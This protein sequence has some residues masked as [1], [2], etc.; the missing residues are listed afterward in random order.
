[1]DEI[2]EARKFKSD[3]ALKGYKKQTL[4][5]VNSY[6]QLTTGKKF[7]TAEPNS[8]QRRA[9]DKAALRSAIQSARAMGLNKKKPAP[10]PAPPAKGFRDRLVR[11]ASQHKPVKAQSTTGG[12]SVASNHQ[13]VKE[14]PKPQT[15]FDASKVKIKQ[16]MSPDAK[17]VE[18]VRRQIMNPM[19]P[20]P[21]PEGMEN[22]VHVDEYL[23]HAVFNA[24][25]ENW[26][27]LHNALPMIKAQHMKDVAMG[28][29][30]NR[31]TKRKITREANRAYKY[32][33]GHA[34]NIEASHN[35]EH[36]RPG[37]LGRLKRAILGEDRVEIVRTIISEASER[38]RKKGNGR[39]SGR[40]RGEALKAAKHRTPG[41]LINRTRAQVEKGLEKTNTSK[42]ETAR[43]N[44]TRA[45]RMQ[46]EREAREKNK[47]YQVT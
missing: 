25:K 26:I 44:E 8:R 31:R 7:K 20:K 23:D 24:G 10:K 46:D 32:R 40:G 34:H 1:M 14:P 19:N 47:Q 6:R 37:I 11:H 27:G 17:R 43:A 41:A 35:P 13:T 22:H 38:M 3:K 16:E 15:G 21:R 42:R 5:L 12:S 4:G 28:Q 9:K 36:V 39:P 30:K 2:E 33:V 18:W 29:G 45:K